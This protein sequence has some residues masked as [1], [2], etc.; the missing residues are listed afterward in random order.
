MSKTRRNVSLVFLALHFG[1]IAMVCLHQTLW[2]VTN[3]LTVIHTKSDRIWNDLDKL[4]AAV[5]GVGLAP[6]NSFRQAV[7]TYMN[8][9]GIEAGYGYFAPN[10]PETHAL[11][12]ECHYPNGRVTY[13]TPMVRSEAGELRLTS[14]IEEI[15]RT[16]FDDWRNE[17][18][19]MLV[20]STWQQHPDAVTV[21]AF[22]GSITPPTAADYCAGKH[23]STFNCLYTYDFDLVPPQATGRS[24]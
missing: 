15:G 12:F 17:L 14:L 10:V 3:H 8:A 24:P 6:E 18:V 20:R 4:P 21:R 2:L 5:L 13:Q 22:F 23:E 1:A 9:A 7:A 19:K 11:V 16:D